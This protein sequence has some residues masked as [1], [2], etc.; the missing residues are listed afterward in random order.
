MFIRKS[1]KYFAD[2]RRRLN[3]LIR[4]GLPAEL[5]G[6]Q[7][8]TN[9][10]RFGNGANITLTVVES[11]DKAEFFQG[12]SFCV[13]EDTLIRMA[14]GTGRPIQD[15]VVGDYVA[16]LEGPRRVN[17]VM[18]KRLDDCVSASTEM[19]VQIH[20]LHHP[21]FSASGWK[22]YSSVL[23]SDSKGAGLSIR[24]SSVPVV[25]IENAILVPHIPDQAALSMASSNER[26]VLSRFYRQGRRKIQNS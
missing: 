8:G 6:P 21:I 10:L 17:F 12:Q 26:R 20:P 16:T 18:P 24:E 1:Y 5:V 23:D 14:D 4:A 25:V 7:Q 13:A 22:S 19:G 11:I 3:Q 15:I 9:Y 2:I